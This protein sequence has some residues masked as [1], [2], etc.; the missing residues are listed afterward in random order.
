[1]RYLL[2]INS[3]IFLL[4]CGSPYKKMQ[5]VPGDPDCPKK[6]KPKFLSDQYKT[7]VDVVG[8]HLSG[9][10]LFKTMPDSS[11]RIV[12]SNEVGF[13]FFDFGFSP[14]SGFTVHYILKQMDKKA[15]IKTLRK[16]FELILMIGT[17][18]QHAYLLK[19]GSKYYHAFPQQEGVNY[20]ITDSVCSQLLG[21]QRSSSRKPVVEAIMQNYH[22][23]IPDTIGIMHK[24]FDFTIGLKYLK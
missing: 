7:A 24:N 9:I 21:L 8:R 6:F 3:F 20:Y 11:V 19:D 4:A 12:F 13:K 1:M 17:D 23:N 2:F 10:L 5:K 22:N 15:V 18:D 14:D 16:D